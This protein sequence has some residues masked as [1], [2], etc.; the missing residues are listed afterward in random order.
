MKAI[1]SLIQIDGW[2]T[3]QDTWSNK[4]NNRTSMDRFNIE[5]NI[6]VILQSTQH[7]IMLLPAS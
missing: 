7:H 3:T 5:S 2:V 1:L 4:T 6:S